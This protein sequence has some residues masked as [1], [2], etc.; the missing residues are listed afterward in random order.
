MQMFFVVSSI[1]YFD[2]NMVQ[3]VH[4]PLSKSK[5]TQLTPVYISRPTRV[6]NEQHVSQIH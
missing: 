5:L 2:N 3:V 4:K 1:I 6:N